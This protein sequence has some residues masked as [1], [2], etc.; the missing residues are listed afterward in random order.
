MDVQPIGEMEQDQFYDLN[1]AWLPLEGCFILSARGSITKRSNVRTPINEWTTA[2]G[3][4]TKIGP[5]TKRM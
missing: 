1:W 5:C 3:I 2:N 4:S